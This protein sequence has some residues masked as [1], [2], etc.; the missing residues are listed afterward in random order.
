MSSSQALKAIKQLNELYQ[1]AN[2]VKDT[3][4]K[5]DGYSG[6]E[7]DD[8]DKA[9]ALIGKSVAMAVAKSV[10]SQNRG[11]FLTWLATGLKDSSTD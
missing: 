9:I 8:M 2:E 4:S 5:V 11:E 3:L 10:T 6:W 7:A 1:K